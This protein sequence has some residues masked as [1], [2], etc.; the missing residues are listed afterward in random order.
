MFSCK[1]RVERISSKLCFT[2][3]SDEGIAGNI[4]KMKNNIILIKNKY[5]MNNFKIKIHKLHKFMIFKRSYLIKN[6]K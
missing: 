2:N 5:K 4:Q 1:G 3:G 6:Q